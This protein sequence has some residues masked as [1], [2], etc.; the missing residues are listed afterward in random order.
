MESLLK[1]E[2]L[3]LQNPK[4]ATDFDLSTK[5]VPKWQ[6]NDPILTTL[7][8]VRTFVA[9]ALVFYSQSSESPT[10][11]WE[12]CQKVLSSERP[13][14]RT[15]IVRTYSSESLSLERPSLEGPKAVHNLFLS[16]ASKRQ[17]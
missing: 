16:I 9:R 8:F 12:K 1:I 4:S 3:I 10:R 14:V 7:D 2:K 5:Y 15:F 17:F 6:I 13:I 11:F